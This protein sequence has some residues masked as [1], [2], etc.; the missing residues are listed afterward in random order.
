MS[1]PVKT[2]NALYESLQQEASR[3]GITIQAAL[4]RRLADSAAEAQ[5]LS[6][7]C[8]K[9]T[10]LLHA[11]ESELSVARSARKVDG[12]HISTLEVEVESVREALSCAESEKRDLAASV[13]EWQA[14]AAELDRAL[15][16][17]RTRRKRQ[18]RTYKGILFVVGGAIL[19]GAVIVLW[20]R[21]RKQSEQAAANREDERNPGLPM[22]WAR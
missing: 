18:A 22:V 12:S 14:Q 17:E 9:H 8:D 1:K 21:R 16:H 10:D 5:R 13:S 7:L 3:L 6:T 11:K 20:K 4:S 19:I 2:S 15:E